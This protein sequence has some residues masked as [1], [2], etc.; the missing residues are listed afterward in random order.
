M[1]YI[2]KSTRLLLKR[3][4][5]QEEKCGELNYSISMLCLNYLH[6][7]GKTYQ[8]FN[9]IIGVLEN[10]KLELYRRRISPYEDGAIER[11]GDL[12]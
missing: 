11:N 7:H 4:D 12:I 3:G 8:T 5:K 10:A 6:N 9:D 1:P 2:K